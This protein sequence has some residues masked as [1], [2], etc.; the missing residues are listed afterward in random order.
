MSIDISG[1]TA[2]TMYAGIRSF[3]LLLDEISEVI[4][5]VPPV[6][7]PVT[8]PFFK[9]FI[10]LRSNILPLIGLADIFQAAA[11]PFVSKADKKY[12]ICSSAAGR[13]ALDIDAVGDTY[14]FSSEQITD[15]DSP[16]LRARISLDDG[17]LQLLDINKLLDHIRALN[18][19]ARSKAGYA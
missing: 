13:C 12:V 1:R 6:P 17:E 2:L 5:P 10:P 18:A 16:L 9:G 7:V 15:A 19:S 11:N 4:E 3:G 14:T 8:H